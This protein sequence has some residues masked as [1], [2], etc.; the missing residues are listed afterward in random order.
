VELEVEVRSDAEVGLAE[1]DEGRD[2]CD[3]VGH[4]THQLDAVEL[5]QPAQEVTP[6]DTEPV[7]DVREEYDGL[8]GALVL[9]RLSRRR[10][11]P[12]LRLG[13]PQPVVD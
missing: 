9:E 4:Q 7:L 12:D 6:G 1:V 2:D 8:A 13:P 3:R 5:Q 10:P 11:P